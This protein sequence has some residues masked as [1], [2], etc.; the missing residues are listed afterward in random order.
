MPDCTWPADRPVLV[1]ASTPAD[2]RLVEDALAELGL[3]HVL[4]EDGVEAMQALC[5]RPSPFA[6]VVVGERVGRVS[7]FTLCGLARDAGYALPM[8]LLT[9][10][11]SRWTAERAARLRLAVLWQPASSRRVAGTLLG[12]LPRRGR[13]TNG[14][15]AVAR[16]GGRRSIGAD[17]EWTSCKEDPCRSND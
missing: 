17:C 8:L 1:A 9:G 14:L 6:A 15:P 16:H 10:D 13:R 4:A 11:D 2:A 12:M 7:G 5:R 3:S